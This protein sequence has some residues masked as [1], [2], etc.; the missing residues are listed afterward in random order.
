MSYKGRRFCWF[1]LYLIAKGYVFIWSHMFR[2]GIIEAFRSYVKKH[3]F[4]RWKNKQNTTI[5]SFKHRNKQ[6]IFVLFLFLFPSILWYQTFGEVFKKLA[7]SLKFSVFFLKPFFPG[8]IKIKIFFECAK[9][10]RKRK[11]LFEF[12]KFI[13]LLN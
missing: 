10:Q 8:K 6:G 12:S 9:T 3:D 13:S 2:E 11:K 5:V 4:P 1:F 7:K